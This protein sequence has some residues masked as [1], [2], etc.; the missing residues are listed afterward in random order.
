[1]IEQQ[2]KLLDPVTEEVLEA[3]HKGGLHTG[4]HGFVDDILDADLTTVGQG[5]H[6][7]AAV[8]VGMEVT[9]A[10]TVKAVEVFR[11]RGGPRGIRLGLQESDRVGLLA[12][13][14]NFQNG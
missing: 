6:G 11:F 1:M 14:L 4:V 3:D 13:F 9:G 5:L 12:C 10:P 2:V 7:D 8:V